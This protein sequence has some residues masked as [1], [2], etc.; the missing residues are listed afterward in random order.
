MYQDEVR[1]IYDHNRVDWKRSQYVVKMH[2][3]LF[4]L[5]VK[6]LTT[7]LKTPLSLL[8]AINLSFLSESQFQKSYQIEYVGGVITLIR[9]YP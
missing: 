4:E 7:G 9:C 1:E 5:G 2:V 6:Q 3:S 8:R